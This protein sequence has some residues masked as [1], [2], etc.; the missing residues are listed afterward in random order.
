MDDGY[1]SPAESHRGMSPGSDPGEKLT[2]RQ[3]AIARALIL[4]TPIKKIAADLDIAPSTVNDHIKA[5]KRKLGVQ[6][7]PDLVASLLGQAPPRPPSNWGETKNRL[8]EGW[9]GGDSTVRDREGSL[10]LS[11]SV[12]L[13]IGGPWKPWS[14]PRV[15]PEELDG[16]E[17]L[18]PRLLAIGKIIALILAAVILAVLAMQAVMGILEQGRVSSG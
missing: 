5:L 3:D 14:E 17:G 11:D 6:S 16:P 13:P 18:V 1:E 7:T 15:V 8:P 9:L 10:L 12:G 2:E 4:R